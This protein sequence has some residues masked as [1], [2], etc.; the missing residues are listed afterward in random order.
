MAEAL[1]DRGIEVAT[2]RE[3]GGTWLGERL[4]EILL[5]DEAIEPDTELLLLFA[6]RAEHLATRIR[7][8][9]RRG[10][11]VLCDRFTDSS[12]AYQGGGRG[13][14]AER[15]ASLESWA[16]GELRPDLTVFLDLPVETSLAR[17]SG[18]LFREPGD[19]FEREHLGFFERVR[20]TYLERCILLPD[21]YLRIDG[22]TRCRGSHPHDPGGAVH[23]T[24]ATTAGRPV[25]ACLRMNST[26]T[27]TDRLPWQEGPWSQ[28]V[29]MLDTG[30]LP[31][32][33]LLHGP[34]GSASAGSRFGSPARS[35]ARSRGP[36]RAGRA[37]PVTF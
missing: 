4:R 27:E 18:G 9:L 15:V 28:L 10:A 23:E 29:T 33:L 8:A 3:P 36:D 11:W 17:I 35:F 22:R 32:A 5:G 20:Q 19:R 34:A 6:A 1:R 2:T 25:V 13:I 24:G 7:P 21:R 31:H 26:A 14:A 30:R 16:Q 37:G 12:Y